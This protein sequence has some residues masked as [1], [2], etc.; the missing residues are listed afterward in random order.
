MK[1]L[2]I[3]IN[4]LIIFS[5]CNHNSKEFTNMPELKKR[6]PDRANIYVIP[7]S[8][9]TGCISPIEEM[10]INSTSTT[11]DYFIFTR[12]KSIKHFKLKFGS[13]FNNKNIII[14]SLNKFQFLEE[15]TSIYPTKNI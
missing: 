9:C 8:G 15:S 1:T 14:G 11:N 12:I 7:G 6:I 2:C 5:S 4:S 13:V 3:F 10:A